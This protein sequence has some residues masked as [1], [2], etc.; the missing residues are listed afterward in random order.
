MKHIPI[1]NIM[2]KKLKVVDVED[3]LEVVEAIF[4]TRHFHHIPVVRDGDFLVGIINREDVLSVTN[5]TL[6]E[7]KIPINSG[8][9][10][11]AKDVMTPRPA[12]LLPD[13]SVALAAEIIL[14]N[15]LHALPVT[16]EKG[17][18]E[19]MVTSHDLLAHVYGNAYAEEL[20][21]R[22]LKI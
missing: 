20:M 12:T 13:D 10:L 22:K 1:K 14:S 17:R 5:K 15:M 4:K 8:I 16:N 2:T 9:A 19:G 3:S 11:K 6:E 7:K 18:L 21:A